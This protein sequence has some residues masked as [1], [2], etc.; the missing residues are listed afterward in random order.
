MFDYMAYP[1]ISNLKNKVEYYIQKILYYKYASNMNSYR[2]WDIVAFKTFFEFGCY[3]ELISS[4]DS[5]F[6][7]I[8]S[9]LLDIMCW[10]E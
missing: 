9:I 10:Q 7:D 1:I 2:L 4:K 6:D 3:Y 8:S 5:S